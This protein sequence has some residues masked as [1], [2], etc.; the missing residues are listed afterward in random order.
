MRVYHSIE[1]GSDEW[2][3]IRKGRPTASRF[4]EIMTNSGA[5]SKSAGGYI[6]EL[7]AECF[8]PD[9]QT[10]AGNIYT[11]RGQELEPEARE[12]FA[13]QTGLTLEQVGFVISE[14]GVCGCSPDSLVVKDGH[15]VAG[16]EIK[17]P[18][19]KAHVGYVLDGIL[20]LLYAQQ[21]HGSMAITGLD[22]WHFWSYFPGMKP[23]HVVVKR[24]DYTAKI[25]TA[26]SEFVSLYKREMDAAIPKLKMEPSLKRSTD[27]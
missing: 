13:A 5:I 27:A 12:A 21:V 10:W 7:I 4:A 16:V 22:E 19:P 9:F 18:T 23:L 11:D 3:A 25:S 1:Q 17:N 2:L 6:R 15:Y 20:P 26:L 14:D 24:D 8:C